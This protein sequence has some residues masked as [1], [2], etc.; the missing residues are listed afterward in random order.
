[1]SDKYMMLL[2]LKEYYKEWIVNKSF[3]KFTPENRLHDDLY[4]VSFPKSGTTW[5]NFIMA[6]VH[7]K[8]SG[9]EQQ[10]TYF[11]II[12]FIPDIMLNRCLKSNILSFPGHR[13]IKSHAEMN[14]LYTKIIYLIRDPRDVMVSYYWFLKNLRIWNEDLHHLI[15]SPIYGIEAW[16][17]HVRGWMEE[18]PAT[19]HISSI[20]YEDMKSDPFKV[21]TQIYN[22]LGHRIPEEI[23]HQAI[24]LSSFENMKKLEEEYKASGDS[25][26]P[27]FKIVRK[28]KI[29]SYR[30]EISEEDLR[31]I[32]EK[33]SR[34]LS[35]FGYNP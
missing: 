25:R 29:G 35:L 14:P 9:R 26:F 32:G 34:W 22:L 11:N 3:A 12:D 7:L 18:T 31:F 16:C 8:M 17:R 24:E 30:T 2:R 6:N 21:M 33:A 28:G 27:E 4:I 1:M 5:L 20:R 15:H 23:L 19:S 10:I 13:V